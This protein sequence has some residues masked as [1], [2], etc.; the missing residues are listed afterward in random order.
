MIGVEM[1]RKAKDVLVEVPR[2]FRDKTSKPILFDIFVIYK[3]Y[4]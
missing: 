3:A 2:L 1:L 4:L